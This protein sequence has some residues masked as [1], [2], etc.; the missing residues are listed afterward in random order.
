MGDNWSSWSSVDVTWAVLSV[1]VLF[2][3]LLGKWILSR[4]SF[5]GKLGAL[6][7]FEIALSVLLDFY[8]FL[9]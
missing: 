2:L 9:S 3:V 6:I 5:E 7:V 8:V 4:R 1:G